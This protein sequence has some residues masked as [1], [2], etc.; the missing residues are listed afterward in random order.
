MH[1][2]GRY[3]YSRWDKARSP[4]HYSGRLRKVAAD[5]RR[6]RIASGG[7]RW[8]R[9]PTQSKKMNQRTAEG[10]DVRDRIDRY[11]RESGLAAR[12]ARV[13]PLT[14]DASDRKYFRIIPDEGPSIV[15]ALHAGSITFADLPFAHVAELMQ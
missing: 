15:L 12:H 8:G 7:S 1:C 14:G 2:D 6:E 10:V 4:C 5:Q 9:A 13:V 3:H 11:L